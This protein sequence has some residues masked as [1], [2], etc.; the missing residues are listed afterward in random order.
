MAFKKDFK[1]E[2]SFLNPEPKTREGA[3]ISTASIDVAAGTVDAV[4]LTSALVLSFNYELGLYYEKLS[5]DPAHVRMDRLNTVAPVLK[6]HDKKVEVGTVVNGVLGA[7]QI[8]GKLRFDLNDPSGEGPNAFRKIREGFTKAVSGGYNVFKLRWLEDHTDGI[9][10]YL[11]VDWEPGEVSTIGIP[12]DIAALIREAGLNKDHKTNIQIIQKPINM[13]VKL[14]EE[15]IALLSETERAAYFERERA[16]GAAPAP[17][18]EPNA[19]EVT[20]AERKRCS[21]ITELSTR[22]DM[23]ADFIKTH[24]EGETG[25]DK[26]RELITDKLLEKQ[27]KV[28]V[29][30]RGDGG[31][32]GAAEKNGAIVEGLLHRMDKGSFP[33]VDG[34]PNQF[35]HRT[36][37]ELVDEHLAANGLDT[38]GSQ[39]QRAMLAMTTRA[40]GMSGSDFA[41][42]FANVLQKSLRKPYNFEKKKWLPLTFNQDTNRINQNSKSIRMTDFKAAQRVLEGGEYTKQ[43]I[44]DKAENFQVN[45]FGFEF[46]ITLEMIIN[47]DLGAINRMAENAARVDW[48]TE[49]YLMWKLIQANPTMADGNAVFSAAHN[50]LATAA[51]PTIASITAARLLMRG[52][53]DESGTPLD[54]A[55][56]Y[57]VA[58]IAQESAINAILSPQIFATK[59]ADVVPANIKSLIP[60]Y[61]AFIP[62]NSFF[63]FADN[64]E[65]DILRTGGLTGEPAWA[66]EQH[67]E[68]KTDEFIW[69]CRKYFGG[70]WV[71]PVG[72][73]F[74]PTSS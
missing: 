68:Y 51:L 4:F 5:F 57:I 48:K 14:T 60:I 65:I 31:W 6:A 41:N 30:N 10:V 26:V 22:A 23:G 40:Q 35:A 38:S 29:G 3:A 16:A 19:K 64:S 58:G 12:A 72:A 28:T 62:D 34:K 36:L 69:H 47:D 18:I 50:N 74:T 15:A 2:L 46:A 45:K 42:I 43:A 71:D 66:M 20:L 13:F 70:A 59:V 21:E 37:M 49:D 17:K 67:Y 52:Q 7:D 44:G 8:S 1:T 63:L 11:A 73:V 61:T 56:K 54:I 53:K 55:P 24:I 33:L 39:R 27:P 9:P 25:I 32:K